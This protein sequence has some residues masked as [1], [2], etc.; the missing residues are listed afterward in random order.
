MPFPEFNLQLVLPDPT[1]MGPALAPANP[2]LSP[3]P[4]SQVRSKKHARPELSELSDP[5]LV[6][7]LP[8][9][10]VKKNRLLWDG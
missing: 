3:L 4:S 1:E 9:V 2:E 10:S 7:T 8:E 6:K 5:F